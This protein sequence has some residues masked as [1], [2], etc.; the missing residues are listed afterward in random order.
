[1]LEQPIPFEPL[2]GHYYLADLEGIPPNTS[3]MVIPKIPAHSLL[4]PSFFLALSSS[5]AL[6]FPHDTTMTKLCAPQ[7]SYP[8]VYFPGNYWEI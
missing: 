7:V 5:R 8:I 2:T 4:P 3:A 1:M 6:I